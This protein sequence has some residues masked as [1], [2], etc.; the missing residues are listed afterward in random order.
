MIYDITGEREYVRL[1][2]LNSPSLPHRTIQND[3]HSPSLRHRIV[4]N[5]GHS[6][7][8]VQNDGH[9]PS[10]RHRIVQNDCHSPSIVQNDRHS[11]S[12][13]L[14]IDQRDGHSPRPQH[15][16]VEH[17]PVLTDRTAQP[18]GHSSVFPYQTT[19]NAG[20]NN[21]P[22]AG[23]TPPIRRSPLL[24]QLSG[25]YFPAAR[26]LSPSREAPHFS[27]GP[28]ESAGPSSGPLGFAVPLSGHLGVVPFPEQRV[29]HFVLPCPLHQP[30]DQ[31][32]WH[33]P[34][35]MPVAVSVSEHQVK[36]T[37]NIIIVQIITTYFNKKRPKHEIFS[38]RFIK[39]SM[40]I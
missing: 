33:M 8:I 37:K 35:P 9:S 4:Q 32:F 30:R 27:A 36:H 22:A 26:Q 1:V 16:T 39:L 6:P 29:A 18:D 19:R 25:Q 11:P 17:S 7:S 15:L 34:M 40:S 38:S 24:S 3:G 2:K 10:L 12:L 20:A 13:H 23:H 21:P 28:L 31:Q 5:D 14:R